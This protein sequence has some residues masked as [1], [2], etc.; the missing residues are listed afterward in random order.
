[1]LARLSISLGCLV[2][3]GIILA[4]VLPITLSNN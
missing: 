1:M 4:I 2:L 3:T